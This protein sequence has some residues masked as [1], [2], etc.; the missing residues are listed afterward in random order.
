VD[1][2]IV[3]FRELLIQPLFEFP[4][5]ERLLND[6]IV[7]EPWRKALQTYGKAHVLG[8]DA[9]FCLQPLLFDIMESYTSKPLLRV[10]QTKAKISLNLSSKLLNR[11]LFRSMLIYLEN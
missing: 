6:L 1:G 9:I 8:Y 11:S 3:P 10:T 4:E 2:Y 5:S 7:S